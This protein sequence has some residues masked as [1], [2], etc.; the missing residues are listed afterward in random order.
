MNCSLPCKCMHSSSVHKLVH[1]ISFPVESQ[2]L[3]CVKS[4]F[5]YVFSALFLIYHESIPSCSSL[6]SSSGHLCI[7]MFLPCGAPRVIF[8]NFWG[9]IKNINS[10]L[11]RKTWLILTSRIGHFC[12]SGFLN[13]C[14]E[15]L[16]VPLREA[17]GL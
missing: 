9:R 11:M 6:P 7:F 15:Q 8:R 4:P 2:H 1:S 13:S 5:V 12:T 10:H 14:S 16:S 17:S 3:W